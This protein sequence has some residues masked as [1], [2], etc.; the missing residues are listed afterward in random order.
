MD[1]RRDGADGAGGAAFAIDALRALAGAGLDWLYPRRCLACEE[2]TAS[3]EALCGACWRETRFIDAPHCR[4][5]GAPLA[6]EAPEPS[7]GPAAACP[8][9][10][11]RP[12]LW[13]EARAATL[14]GGGA[15]RLVLALKHGDRL[16][17]AQP[18]GRWMARAGSDLLTPDAAGRPPYVVPAP[19][20]WRRRL[21]RRA[22]Q[23]AELAAVIA[24]R[25]G[26]P[27]AEDA[28][29]RRRATPSLHG[30]TVPE[31]AAALANAIAVSPRWA[32]R[33][34]EARV[35]LVDD[36]LTTGATLNA[37]AAALR[38]AGAGAVDALV[39]ARAER[40]LDDFS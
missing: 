20:H 5:C 31:R 1:Q 9:C 27:L 4:R 10:R 17:A 25:T 8:A 29:R 2:E 3:L 26:A 40:S 32:T 37:C 36:V 39:F 6:F 34:K 18:M 38:Q 19:L 11:D 7:G 21:G 33:L 12:A 13:R 15:R 16:E 22:N 35:V 30:M 23:S 28:L 14:Y 24:G